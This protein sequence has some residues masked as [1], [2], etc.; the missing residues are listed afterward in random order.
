LEKKFTLGKEERLKSRKQTEKLFSEGRKFSVG[1]FRVC[2]LNTGTGLLFGVGVSAKTFKKAVDRNR[3]K[4]LVRE[5]WR[6]QKKSLGENLMKGN[7]GLS[8]FFIYTGKELPDYK[9][10]FSTTTRALDKL[11]QIIH[12]T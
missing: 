8:V 7:T 11:E 3:V 9:D 12:K 6:L 10:V 1:F 4:R 5:A 2:Y